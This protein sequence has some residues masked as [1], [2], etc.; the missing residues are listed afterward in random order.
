[1]T[2][3]ECRY[4]QIEKGTFAIVFALERF[5]QYIYGRTVLVQSDHQPI[6]VSMKKPLHKAY[7]AAKNDAPHA[8]I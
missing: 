7:A 8:E 4:A 1:M 2:D 6:D 5:H 3:T